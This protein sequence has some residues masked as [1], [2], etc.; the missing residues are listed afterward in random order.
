VRE[1][2]FS[3]CELSRCELSRCELSRCERQRKFGIPRPRARTPLRPMNR[4]SID[5]IMRSVSRRGS[6]AVAHGKQAGRDAEGYDGRGVVRDHQQIC[7]LAADHSI[8][9]AHHQ[10]HSGRVSSGVSVRVRDV[11]LEEDRVSRAQAMAI[12]AHGED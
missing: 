11:G 5:S 10:V 1:L 7:R 2:C 3:R 4:Q 8:G 6:R 12:F 9:V